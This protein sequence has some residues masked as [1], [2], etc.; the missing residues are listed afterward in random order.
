M[1]AWIDCYL[2][3]NRMAT[4]RQIQTTRTSGVRTPVHDRTVE[5]FD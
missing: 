2:E 1:I 3:N 4:Y 5:D